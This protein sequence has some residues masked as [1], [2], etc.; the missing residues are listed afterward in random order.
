M[1]FHS[2]GNDSPSF[3]TGPARGQA[4][5]AVLRVLRHSM[6]RLLRATI[7]APRGP[8]ITR[9]E[10]YRRMVKAL[11]LWPTKT[12]KV[13]SISHSVGLAELLG[14]TATDVA[15]ANYPDA[16][17]LALDFPDQTFD[18]VV[19]DQVLEHV[20]GDPLVAM[21]ECLRVVKPGGLVIHTTCFITPKH[22][23]PSDF[24]RFT[25]EGLRLLA[26]DYT[27]IVDVSGWGNPFVWMVAALGLVR[28]PIPHAT[29]HPLHKLATYDHPEWP[30]VTWIIAQR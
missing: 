8:H 4:P 15:H 6:G 16:N 1:N 2:G 27:R 11:A 30:V 23:A 20:E 5:K 9:Y 3:P 17:I 22:G 24:W 21:R 26:A 14:I 19:A 25:P 12:G 29:W 10:M 18:F 13:L 28:E 7:P